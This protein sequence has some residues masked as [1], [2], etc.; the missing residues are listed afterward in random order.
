MREGKLL[1]EALACVQRALL[2]RVTPSLRGVAVGDEKRMVRVHCYYDGI[3]SEEEAEDISVAET[4]LLADFFG[5][6]QLEFEV[7]RCDFPNEMPALDGWAYLRKEP[8]N[9]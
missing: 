8:T 9:G 2:D 3:P 4:E 7:V 5:I 6:A 1:H